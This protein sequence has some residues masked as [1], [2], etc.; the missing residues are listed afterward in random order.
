MKMNDTIV[1]QKIAVDTTQFL[2]AFY[3]VRIFKS[4]FQA[5]CDSLIYNQQDS[6][7]YLYKEPIVWSDTSQFV[8]DTI[9]IAMKNDNIDRIYLIDNAFIINSPD[10]VLYNQV[11]GRKITAYFKK[12]EI[13]KM[14]VEGN[15]E[16]VYYA[17]DDA[18]QYIG[19]NKTVSSEMTLFFEKNEITRIKFLEPD[20]NLLPINT[21]DHEALK[22]AGFNWK[23]NERPKS[24][25]AL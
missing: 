13:D 12:G 19:V 2:K 3:D 6:L 23:I 17:L 1:Q 4:N 7:F 20:A 11:K 15:A 8:A 9:K 22:I 24:K 21:T 5:L 14:H 10:E 25:A 18:D 16:A